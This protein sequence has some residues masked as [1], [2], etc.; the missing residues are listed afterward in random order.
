MKAAMPGGLLLAVLTAALATAAGCGGTDTMTTDP[1]IRRDN[2]IHQ[3]WLQYP[4]TPADVEAKLSV[5]GTPFGLNNPQWQRL[6]ALMRPGDQLWFYSNPGDAW[7]AHMGE[8]GYAIV[9]HDKVWTYIVSR[10]N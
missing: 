8:E 4:T 1:N 5:G 7:A 10:K 6:K 3:R 9:R 2:E